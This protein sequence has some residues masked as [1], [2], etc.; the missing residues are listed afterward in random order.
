MGSVR[1]WIIP[2]RV[3]LVTGMSGSGKSIA[4][5][6]LEDSGYAVVDNLPARFLLE[7]IGDLGAR[8][9]TRVAV[10]IDVRSGLD[11]IAELPILIPALRRLGHDVQMLFLT[12]NS[13]TLV[14]R[15]SET[16][17]RHPLSTPRAGIDAVGERPLDE[18]IAEERQVLGALDGLGHLIDTSE[19]PAQALRAWVRDFIGND[20]T[21]LTLLFESFAYKQG[22]P[23][24]GDLVFDVRCL[25]N[26]FY[27]KALRPLT[28]LDA[29]VIAYLAAIRDVGRMIDD[30]EG[31]V[32]RWLPAYVADNR[33]YL[34][35][36]IGCTGGQHRS[37]YCVEELA[38]RLRHVQPVL[39]RHRALAGVSVSRGAASEF[40]H[41]P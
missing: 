37:V 21:G 1:P 15:Y 25:P 3:V 18:C 28:G 5:H 19:L 13:P 17:R 39:V 8:G 11:A 16:R 7:V 30:I 35:V 10:S 22:V 12:A 2:M 31:F 38:S 32:L 14:Q 9:Q 4:L 26:P 33:S 36:A 29:P 24:D 6:V 23:L 20:R 27:D 40:L 41:A 34:T